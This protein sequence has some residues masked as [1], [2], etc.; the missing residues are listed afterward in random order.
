MDGLINSL[1][2]G[3]IFALSLKFS[4]FLYVIFPQTIV[5]PVA[6]PHVTFVPVGFVGVIEA[7]VPVIVPEF[8]IVKV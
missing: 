2:I 8:L 1:S 6:V 5:E 7:N 4:A 3:R